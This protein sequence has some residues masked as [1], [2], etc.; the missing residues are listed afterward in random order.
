MER[1]VLKASAYSRWQYAPFAFSSNP[2]VLV[3]S[4][5][6]VERAVGFEERK[7]N[8]SAGS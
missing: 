7:N 6:F 3:G 4:A 5:P 2:V 1:A 8:G